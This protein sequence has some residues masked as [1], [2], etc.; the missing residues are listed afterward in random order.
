M[1][2]YPVLL[3]LKNKKCCVV[4]GGKVAQRKVQNLLKAGACVWVISPVLT[5]GLKRLYRT[6]KI[7]YIKNS[8]QKRFIKDSFL[9]IAA[10]DNTKVNQAVFRDACSGRILTNI[11]DSPSMSNFIVPSLIAKNGLII[12]IS[13]SAK[14]PCLARKIRM[15]LTRQFLPR[16]AKFLKLLEGVREELKAVCPKGKT[17]KYI[18]TKLTNSNIIEEYIKK[19]CK[20]NPREILNKVLRKS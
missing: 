6:K 3:D 15:D 10:T 4:G 12:S 16:Y 9:V 14:A 13:T 11:V 2:Y 19:G 5:A 8:Y 1:E 17:R 18:M 7:F 20:A